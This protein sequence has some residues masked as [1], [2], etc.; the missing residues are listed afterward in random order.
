MFGESSVIEF[1][2]K[3]GIFMYPILLCSIVGL[4]IF[5]Q[6]IWML[7]VKRIIPEG[8]LNNLY[9]YLSQ[10]K[11]GEAIVLSRTN[12]ASIARIALTALENS[13]KS[14]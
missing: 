10:G 1:M 4:A 8:F 6:K 7:R 5:L 14:K 9:G 12:G 3:G 11:L 13:N 2:R